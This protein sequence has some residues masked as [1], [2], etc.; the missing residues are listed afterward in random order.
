MR[1]PQ[2]SSRNL[3]INWPE[4]MKRR[5]KIIVALTF[6]LKANIFS[7]SELRYLLPEKT[8]KINGSQIF[9]TAISP[10]R[11]FVNLTDTRQ[12]LLAAPSNSL[13]LPD[14][15]IRTFA[16]FC[17]KEFQFE[18]ATKIPLRFRLGSLEYCNKL[19]GK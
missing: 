8:L 4:K 13:I 9:G 1:V 6:M 17:R 3:H 7:Q 19:E 12:V 11:F 15:S 18:K 14:Y 5:I 2:K 10:E 16:F